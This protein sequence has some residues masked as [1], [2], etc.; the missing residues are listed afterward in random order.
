MILYAVGVE[1]CAICYGSFA[2]HTVKLQKSVSLQCEEKWLK[3]E[4]KKAGWDIT[5]E[6]SI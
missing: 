4:K 1:F 3:Q 6:N 5:V 2:F